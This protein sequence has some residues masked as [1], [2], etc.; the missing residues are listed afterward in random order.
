MPMYLCSF[1]VTTK[2]TLAVHPLP[3]AAVT[4]ISMYNVMNR[5]SVKC[6]QLRWLSSISYSGLQAHILGLTFRHGLSFNLKADALPNNLSF[7]QEF[8]QLKL[9][10]IAL[11][12]LFIPSSLFILANA[13]V[14]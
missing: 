9:N 12:Q 7:Y 14:T 5:M 1:L 3:H 11:I 2:P 10:S 13:I 4:L 8:S 6:A